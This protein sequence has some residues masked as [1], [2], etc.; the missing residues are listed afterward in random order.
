MP[1]DVE[2]LARRVRV[3]EAALATDVDR[4]D[5]RIGS[6]PHEGPLRRRV[7]VLEEE[8]MTDFF[9]EVAKGNVVGSKIVHKFGRND[10]VP[11]SAWERISLASAPAT[12]LAAASTMRI[13]A[14]GNVNDTAAGTGAQEVTLEGLDET[15][16]EAT[17]TLATAG[18][19]ASLA[20]ATSFWRVN[21][22]Y[23][24]PEKVGV[25]GGANVADIAI[26]AVTGPVD[27]III[28]ADTGSSFFGGYS[29]PLGKTALFLSGFVTV[30]SGKAAD[31]RS[32][33][34]ENLR[35]TVAPSPIRS[36]IHWVGL[37]AGATAF[38]PRSPIVRPALTDF[39]IEARGNGGAAAVSVDFELLVV[40]K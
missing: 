39:W 28:E 2:R 20:T 6:I 38:M 13:K 8:S 12:F 16:A 11:T 30:D 33:F 26:E 22:A 7:Q 5:R 37:P 15:G 27:Q 35:S 32:R 21:R 34:R 25:Y 29:V 24:S 19:S 14:G 9:V 1:V 3:L 4:L 10:A 17:E 18:V 23:V 40:D 31:I 36:V